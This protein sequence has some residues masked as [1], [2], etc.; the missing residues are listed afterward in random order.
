MVFI[1]E[2]SIIGNEKNLTV[3]EG[4]TSFYSNIAFRPGDCALAFCLG[5][6][7]FTSCSRYSFH[8]SFPVHVLQ[9]CCAHIVLYDRS[10]SP[11]PKGSNNHIER[12]HGNCANG[13]AEQPGFL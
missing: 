6:S 2:D 12:C 1:E 5:M 11:S 9:T 13:F 4:T 8:H 3:G 7:G 10:A